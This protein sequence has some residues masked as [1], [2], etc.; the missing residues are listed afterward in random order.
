MRRFSV[1]YFSV[2]RR[3]ACRHVGLSRSFADISRNQG[4]L[5]LAETERALRLNPRNLDA[6]V[7]R[8]V[9]QKKL[10]RCAEVVALAAAMTA[11][12]C[13]WPSHPNAEARDS[14][15]FVVKEERHS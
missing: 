11:E 7:L 14:S 2:T 13:A 10:G 12:L 4:G 1:E 8:I 3:L 9:L 15:I 5:A 6:R